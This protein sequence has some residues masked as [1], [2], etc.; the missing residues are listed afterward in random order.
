[1]IPAVISEIFISTAEIVMPAGTKTNE[2]NAEIETQEATV[3]TKLI[4]CST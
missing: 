2:A 4:K 1:M 3:E